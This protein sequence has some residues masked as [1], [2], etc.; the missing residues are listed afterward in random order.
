MAIASIPKEELAHPDPKVRFRAIWNATNEDNE[1]IVCD[2]C[3]NTD[4]DEEE[5]DIIICA[6][7]Q[8][9]RHATAERSRKSYHQAKNNGSASD[10]STSARTLTPPQYRCFAVFATMSRG[11]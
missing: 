10:A 4:Q 11:L 2:I 8:S 3:L 6:T 9:I 5:D 7:L 1:K